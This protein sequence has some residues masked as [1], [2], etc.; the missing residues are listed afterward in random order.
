MASIGYISTAVATARADTTLALANFNFEINLFTKRVNPPVEYSGV[1]QHLA[2][3]RL[4]EAQDGAQHTTARRLGLLFKNILPST[5]GL[6]RAYGTRASEISRSAKANPKGDASSYGPFG[7]RVGADATALWAAATSGHAAIQC[8]LLAC[9]LARIWDAPEATSLWDEIILR[10]KTEVAAKLEADC[11]I[12]T[13]TMLAA[14][15]QFPR[16]D[17]ADWDAS[18]RSWLRV[19]DSE[20]SVQQTKL[21]L[22]IDN[23]DLSVN[24]KPDTY[25]SVLAAWTTAMKEMEKLLE[26]IHLP[27]QSGGILLALM[28][29]HLYPDLECLTAPN[30]RVELGDRLFLKRGIL[31]IGL[32]PAPGREARSVYWSLPLAHLRYYGLPVT[33]FCSTR[34]SE[35][36]RVTV[37]ELLFAW[38]SAY[39]KAWDSDPSIPSEVVIR[40]VGDVAA[41]LH[42]ALGKKI[43]TTGHAAHE[44]SKGMSSPS[45]SWLLLLS[46]IANKWATS[47]DQP[48][49]QSLRNL[50]RNFSGLVKAPFQ[51]IFTINTYLEVAMELED[52]IRLLREI[53]TS[54]YA[55]QV[56]DEDYKYLI[57]YSY[58]YEG[59]HRGK[60]EVA[61]ACPEF[62]IERGVV[63]SAQTPR[64]Y[65]R[66]I[67]PPPRG[68][69]VQPSEDQILEARI[70]QIRESGE[71]ADHH[72]NPYPVFLKAPGNMDYASYRAGRETRTL[73]HG[74]QIEL[75]EKHP[76][77]MKI[78]RDSV[79]R[80]EVVYGDYYQGVALL[81]RRGPTDSHL[82]PIIHQQDQAGAKKAEAST[83]KYTLSTK[84]LLSLFNP[85]RINFDSLAT[86]YLRLDFETNASLLGMTFIDTLYKKLENATVDVRAAKVD[87]SKAHWVKSAFENYKTKH[88]RRGRH[89]ERSLRGGRRDFP[90]DERVDYL[91]PSDTDTAASFACIAMMET[92]SFN[93][94]PSEL[95][96]VFALCS[97]DSMYIASALLRDPAQRDDLHQVGIKRVTGNIGRAGMALMIPPLNPTV[98]SYEVDDWYLYQ[99]QTFDGVL[100]DSFGGTSLQL[101]FTEWKQEVNVGT[102]GS[103]DVEAYF[104]ETLISV[105]DRDK[106][107]ADLDVLSTFRSGRLL[108]S[109]LAHKLC[110][111]STASNAQIRPP[112]DEPS[113][114]PG[115]Q[116]ISIGNFAEIIVA[117][118]GPG[119]ITAKG[120][121]QARLAAASICIAKGY[122]VILK[123][124]DCC[125]RC[126]SSASINGETV[127]SIIKSSNVLVIIL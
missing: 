45:Q 83:A 119:I 65:R 42:N 74:P 10:R 122:R 95:S 23:I 99:H 90:P 82:R 76:L 118:S 126:L 43:Y 2:K 7:D 13:D 38:F 112:L 26:G 19:A 87:L 25:E 30:P 86:G 64:A 52:K 48:R 37:D 22:I 67:S 93:F 117:P 84:K 127:Y 75:R 77:V 44:S 35:T 101:S 27:V 69:S 40:Y 108:T 12:D 61:T 110:A 85:D 111:C 47:L 98:R 91:A 81:R 71:G 57:L 20:K 72:S 68:N 109:F 106:W 123:P 33:K 89:G 104:L 46:Q 63:D 121:W 21:R 53:A 28:A 51:N 94:H 6:I 56:A 107:I 62:G 66:W 58:D 8:H 1:G 9:M 14:A 102:T 11:E 120:N 39:I 124:H 17:L 34:T 80:Y 116:L 70:Q 100:D 125:W 3:S 32:G 97:A 60:F 105:Y 96:S 4:Q 31:T 15:G 113:L 41:R 92:G 54:L 115:L 18:C 59:E 103:K 49:A 88:S 78:S 5:P 79:Y 73:I 16:S 114:S 55:Q 29:W 50:G 36:D 24:N